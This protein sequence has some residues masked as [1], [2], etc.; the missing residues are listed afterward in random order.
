MTHIQVYNAAEGVYLTA[1]KVCK[2]LKSINMQTQHN[3]AKKTKKSNRNRTHRYLHSEM[4]DLINLAVVVAPAHA[5][6]LEPA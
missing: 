6:Q 4:D 1:T 2:R 5:P 3:P